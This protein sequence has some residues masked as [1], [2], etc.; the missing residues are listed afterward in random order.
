MK[1][2]KSNASVSG[3]LCLVLLGGFAA[4]TAQPAPP[5]LR[6][7]AYELWIETGDRELAAWQV[8]VTD[9]AAHAQLVGLEGGSAGAY[10]EAP[11][12]DPAALH[13]HRVIVAAFSL[14]AILPRGRTHVATLHFAL[15]A[16]SDP[17]FEIVP[18]AAADPSGASITINAVLVKK[19][20]R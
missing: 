14:E 11:Y 16:A 4:A 15:D 6:F 3:L 12:Y 13:Q 19:E 2:T 10:S 9:P 17:A 1:Q 7:A 18:I 8:E 20:Q 5:E